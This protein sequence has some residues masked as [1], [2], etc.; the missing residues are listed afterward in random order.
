LTDLRFKKNDH[1]KTCLLLRNWCLGLIFTPCFTSGQND[2][3]PAAY[4][5]ATGP[6]N[7]ISCNVPLNELNSRACR[8]FHRLFRTVTGTEFW[9]KSP[10]GYQVDFTMAD[11]HQRQAYFDL[12]G[13]YRY[14]VKFYS[15]KEIPR[16]QG[17]LIRY[18]FAGYQ[19]NVVTE[20]TDG[21]KIV[22][23]VRIFNPSNVKN[24]C[25]CE[26]KID[27]LEEMTNGSPI[28]GDPTAMATV[29]SRQSY[30]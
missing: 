20:I 17:D 5:H 22:Y 14:S 1:M 10:D 19:I 24:V 4:T 13:F 18:R 29:I 15:G 7:D 27:V 26:G 11:G 6:G 21:E 28:A 12:K 9:I 25:I 8:H 16:E 30:P 2:Y 23:L 3:H